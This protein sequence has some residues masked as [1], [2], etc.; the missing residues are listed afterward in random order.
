MAIQRPTHDQ[1]AARAYEI[2]IARGGAH[3]HDNEDWQQAERELM[4]MPGAR[5]AETG[6][7]KVIRAARSKQRATNTSTLQRS[8]V[9]AL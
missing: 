1:I 4:Q 2:F 9:A 5:S 7:P 8:E 6:M 3:G